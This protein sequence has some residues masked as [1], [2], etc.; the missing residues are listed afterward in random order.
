MFKQS[1]TKILFT[2]QK[3]KFRN[4]LLISVVY[5]LLLEVKMQLFK[6][7]RG[8]EAERQRGRE[9]ERFNFSKGRGRQAKQKQMKAKRKQKQKLKHGRKDAGGGR[10]G[11]REEG[12][13]S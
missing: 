6:K 2:H 1:C 11:R 7:R 5:S 3:L 9:A 8:R 4:L 13:K 10:R 12:P